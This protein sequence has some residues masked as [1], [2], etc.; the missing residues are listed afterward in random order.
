MHN[1][2]KTNIS[3]ILNIFILLQPILDLITGLCVN[4]LNTNITLGIIIRI[5]FL[6][7]IMYITIFVYKKKLSLWVYIS[8]IFY[9][10]LYL[11]GIISFNDG[12]LFQELQGLVKVFYFPILLISLYDLKDDV[13]ISNKTLLATLTMYLV[14]IFIPIVLNI[15]FKSYQI[16]KSGTLGFY[17]SANEISGIISLLTP[18]MFIMLK[19]KKN[20][21]KKL[22]L[23][24]IYLVVILTVG[25][26]TP[27]LALIMTI[28]ATLGYYMINCL[29]KKT[30]KPIAYTAVIVLIGFLSLIM[31]LPKTN[32]YKNIEVH[33]DFLEVDNVYE[34][35]TDYKLIDHFIFSQ[36]LTFLENKHKLYEQSNLYEKLN[37]IGYVKD[38]QVT[39]LIEMDYFDIYYSHGLF[40]F[41][42]LFGIYIYVLI[43]LL[44]EKQ[45][46]TYKRTMYITSFVL[47]LLLSLF[48]GHIIT[49]PA[50]SLIVVVLLLKLNIKEISEEKGVNMKKKKALISVV[51]PVYNVEKYLEECIES[52]VN[53]TYD[54]IELIFI[55]DG[56]T[57][58]S[59]S[60]L[61]EY[62]K[63]NKSIMKVINNKNNGIG[64]TRN[65]GIEKANG[66]FIYFVDS[67]DYV[68]KD[69]LKN[70]Y[71]TAV[72]EDADIVI[73]DMYRLFNNKDLSDKFVVN[74]ENGNIHEH[75]T[76]LFDI[77]L[78]PCGKLFKKEILTEHFPENLKYE[79]VPFTSNALKNSKKTVKHNEYLYYYRI[80]QNSETTSMDKRVFDILEILK[81]TNSFYKKEKD[82]QDE[83]EYLN[84][85]LLSRYNLQQ[86]NQ[87]DKKLAEEFLDKSFKHLSE[88]FP[89]WKKNKY[90]KKRN[91]LKRIIET[92]KF[93]IKCY[94]KI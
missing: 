25:T 80:H 63:K 9:S 20:I 4:V 19:E 28:G 40:G 23:V 70:M 16:T 57:D 29:K 93:L 61:K 85:Q 17:N 59:L 18:I 26:K 46:L 22:L 69:A 72:K 8:I 54:N 33:L 6:A 14:F 50:V 53:Q 88:N 21:L 62:Q 42:L 48:T 58:S 83:L 68:S 66:E 49:A 7:L 94:W 12:L 55:N 15:G 11:I 36:R 13:R 34:V 52:L 87:K 71:E 73:S 10:V 74:F 27:L 30:Y 65:I 44:K 43:K 77:P 2:F 75:K 56:S 39:K 5:L 45:T 79:D 82:L 76:Q 3:K 41:L 92:N 84:I 78:G 91:I 86:K 81:L 32:F 1:Y 31:I 24:I 47:I 67:D 37:G 64:K 89:N 35:F 90:L 60:I 38:N 51:V